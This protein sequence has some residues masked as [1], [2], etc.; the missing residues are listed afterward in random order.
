MIELLREWRG[1]AVLQLLLRLCDR[2]RALPLD[3]PMARLIVAVE[4]SENL[5]E[6]SL[7][8][9]FF[10]DVFCFSVKNCAIMPNFSFGRFDR[11]EL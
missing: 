7:E 10:V 4:V 9:Q 8:V 5:A 3:T 2:I 6:K 11:C 1:H